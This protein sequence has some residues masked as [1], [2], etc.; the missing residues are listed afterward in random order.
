MSRR[1]I[2]TT[3]VAA[4][5][6]ASLA[7]VPA[8][9]SAQGG[10]TFTSCSTVGVCGWVTAIFQGSVLTVRVANKDNVLGSALFSTQLFFTSALNS[11]TLGTAYQS[12]TSFGTMDQVTTIGT[13][14]AWAFSGVGGSNELD[15]AAFTN[16][17][18]EGMAVSPFRALPGDPDNGT[19]V[20]RNG[21]V[22][23]SADL[24]G[25]TGISQV[26]LAGLGFCT[27][28][29]CASGTPVATPEPATIGL[30]ATGLI[31]IAAM[32]RRRKNAA[33]V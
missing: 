24:S 8:T 16:S 19:W 32:R 15:L 22:E 18:I 7:S 4:A 5:V 10:L 30:V 1:P 12:G 26:G 14:G 27:D 33:A 28:Q 21:F 25:V 9:A 11:A 3:L 23:F 6:S 29:G 13:V 20:T 17:Y 31:G 2:R